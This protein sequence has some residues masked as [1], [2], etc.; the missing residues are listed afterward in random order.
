MAE[1]IAVPSIS[2]RRVTGEAAIS[3]V[4]APAQASEPPTP[5][6]KRAIPSDHASPAKPKPRL[7]TPMSATPM[8]RARRGP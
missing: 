6:A 3:Q 2:P 5:W 4:R 8:R 7:A 1:P